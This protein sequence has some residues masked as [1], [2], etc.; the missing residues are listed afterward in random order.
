[1]FKRTS[2]SDIY[3]TKGKSFHDSLLISI[4]KQMGLWY[5]P[6][7]RLGKMFLPLPFLFV[8]VLMK[9]Y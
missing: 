8:H 9:I 3:E 1:M 5:E 7:W 4:L 6:A 2:A